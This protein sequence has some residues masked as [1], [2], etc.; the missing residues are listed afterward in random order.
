MIGN[1]AISCDPGS[2]LTKYKTQ[3]FVPRTKDWGE[4]DNTLHTPDYTYALSDPLPSDPLP[5]MYT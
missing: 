5:V 2:H 1:L 3:A 4:I